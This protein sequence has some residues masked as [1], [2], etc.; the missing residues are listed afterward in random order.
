[1]SIPCHQEGMIQAKAEHVRGN[2]PQVFL[3]TAWNNGKQ[4]VTKD[5]GDTH[6][7][8]LNTVDLD[9]NWSTSILIGL[10]ERTV[11]PQYQYRHA[12]F[13]RTGPHDKVGDP[14]EQTIHLQ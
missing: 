10:C 6:T 12:L 1:M 8:I 7:Q 2:V 3:G 9:I 5:S 13:E 11:H 4:M 14:F